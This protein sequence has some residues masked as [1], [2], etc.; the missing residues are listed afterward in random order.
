M[1]SNLCMVFA[2]RTLFFSS[3][4]KSLLTRD[5]HTATPNETDGKKTL[6]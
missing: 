4:V 6:R 3:S 2:V 5:P 1:S